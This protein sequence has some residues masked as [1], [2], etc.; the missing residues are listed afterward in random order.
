MSGLDETG[1]E[2]SAVICNAL[3]QQALEGSERTDVQPVDYPE[4]RTLILSY[5]SIVKISNLVDLSA[6]TKLCLDNNRLKK[7]EG[8]EQL[9]QLEWLDLSFND[10]QSIDGLDHLVHLRDLSLAHNQIATLTG[11]DA[12]TASLEVLSIAHNQ[13]DSLEGLMYLRAFPHLRVLTCS[14]NPFVSDDFRIYVVAHLPSLSYLD[15]RRIMPDELKSATD[16]YTTELLLL[17]EKEDADRS[18][19]QLAAA[20]EQEKEVLACCDALGIDCLVGKDLLADPETQRTLLIPAVKAEIEGAYQVAMAGLCSE[21]VSYLERRRCIRGA[22]IASFEVAYEETV[23]S[24]VEQAALPLV[25][26]FQLQLEALKQM[27]GEDYKKRHAQ[28]LDETT[29]LRSDLIFGEVQLSSA[30]A[31]M[32]RDFGTALASVTQR[33]VE[34]MQYLLGN[35][36]ARENELYVV[37]QPLIFAAAEAYAATGSLDGLA[38]PELGAL[39]GD[40]SLLQQVTIGSHEGRLTAVDAAEDDILQS[41]K[42]YLEATLAKVEAAERSRS[43]EYVKDMEKLVEEL[44][45]ILDSMVI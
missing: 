39:L 27:S 35:V 21:V 23:A 26:G 1:V 6:L 11:L 43:R 2:E 14:G 40:K 13:L 18:Q 42:T 41:Q 30:V 34:G 37:V 22:E 15:Y 8:L 5:K 28:L 17:K 38:S 10:I 24:Y 31:V 36:R 25:S 45:Q 32:L 7:I 20:L 9:T 33:T 3:I 44:R 12:Q 16:Q 19:R 4:I 29:Q